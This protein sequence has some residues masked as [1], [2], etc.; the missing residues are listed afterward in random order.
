[1]YIGVGNLR[2]SSAVCAERTPLLSQ[3]KVPGCCGPYQCLRVA[4]QLRGGQ[5]GGQSSCC[6]SCFQEI[7][8]I[9]N[10]KIRLILGYVL[11]VTHPLFDNT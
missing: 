6:V 3:E 8:Q 10:K 9:L 2:H 7:G 4:G 11:C 1:M 5:S